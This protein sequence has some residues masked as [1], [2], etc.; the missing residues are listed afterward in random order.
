MHYKNYISLFLLLTSLQINAQNDSLFKNGDKDVLL[1]F[2]NS[3][4]GQSLVLFNSVHKGLLN[5]E[6]NTLKQ[7]SRD[8]LYNLRNKNLPK[9]FEFRAKIR[10]SIY[11]SLKRN[12]E[13]SWTKNHL[14]SNCKL[15]NHKANSL[16]NL[17][18]HKK[19]IVLLVTK[20]VYIE[21]NT[22][23]VFQATELYGGLIEGYPIFHF[24]MKFNNRWSPWLEISYGAF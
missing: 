3:F 20:P 4:K 11:E 18:E 14:P 17:S 19:D 10:D 5:S 6:L 24:Y 2:L 15:I 9:S 21:N 12:I 16:L 7:D 22:I 8:S 13:Y 1:A 23:A